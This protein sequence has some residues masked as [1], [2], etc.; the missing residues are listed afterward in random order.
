LGGAAD[1]AHSFGVRRGFGQRSTVDGGKGEGGGDEKLA[2]HD[3]F[4][5]LEGGK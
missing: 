1:Q 2:V 3:E 5:E 4:L